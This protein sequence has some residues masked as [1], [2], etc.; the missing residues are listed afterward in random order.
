[1]VEELHLAHF[2]VKEYLLKQDELDLTYSSIA[3]TRTCVV[4]LGAYGDI[5]DSATKV[6]TMPNTGQNTPSMLRSPMTLLGA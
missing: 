3:I 2:S 1:M 5:W 6:L 4:Y